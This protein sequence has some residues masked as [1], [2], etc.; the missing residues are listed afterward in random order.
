MSQSENLP[1]VRSLP[2]YDLVVLGSGVLAFIASFFPYYGASVSGSVPGVGSFGSSS[3]SVTA[4]H[5]YSTLALLLIF[6]GTIAAAAAIFARDSLN[7]PVDARW[8][9]AGL[10]ALGAFLYLIRLFTL[11]SH[12]V[13][14]GAGISA[15]E[16]V[17]WGGYLLLIIVLVNAAAAVMGALSS[18]AP[19][20]WAQPTASGGGVPSWSMS[21]PTATPPAAT[22]PPAQPPTPAPPPAGPPTTQMSDPPP[23]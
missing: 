17:R 1:D 6:I 21:P 8:A 12:H 16:G 4:W 7:M 13:T 15:S 14:L 18:D 9:A 19:A 2:P 23:L 5:S 22:P 10:C 11:P 20:P 3:T